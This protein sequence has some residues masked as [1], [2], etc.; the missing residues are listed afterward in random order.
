MISWKKGDSFLTLGGSLLAPDD[1]FSVDLTDSSSTLTIT[2]VKQEDAGQYVCQVATT[3]P[4]TKTFSIEIKG[5]SE[6]R[7]QILNHFFHK[8]IN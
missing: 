1:R 6:Q 8:D 3:E 2:L 5:E 4:L 7:L